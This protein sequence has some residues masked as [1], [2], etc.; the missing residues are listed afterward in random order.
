[1]QNRILLLF[2][3]GALFQSTKDSYAQ[4]MS[5]MRSYAP[6]ETHAFFVGVSGGVNYVM[7]KSASFPIFNSQPTCFTTQNGSGVSPLLGLNMEIP[8]NAY[9]HGFIIV[10]ALYDSKS[11]A[12]NSNNNGS[13]GGPTKI[14]GNVQGGGITTGLTATLTYLDVNVGYKYNFTESPRPTGFGVQLCASLGAKLAGNFNK[15]VTVSASS[16][17]SD[18]SKTS[19]SVT[20]I[21]GI[22]AVRIGLRG[23]F[24]YD[25]PLS[26]TLLLTPTIGY[27]LPFSA[28]DNTDRS[29][30]ASSV[31]GGV[32]L[33]YC[34]GN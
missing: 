34:F 11:A 19:K 13:S 14:D 10:E 7:Y 9:M 32:M 25:I 24:T 1:M 17:T 29:W 3:T 31:Y 12:F 15:T 2:I 22:N 27:D 30:K 20:S 28:V 6:S 16:G 5:D 23:Q 26:W 4:Q 18:I 21:D 8:V 33:H